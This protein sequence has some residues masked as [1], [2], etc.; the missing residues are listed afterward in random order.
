[1]DPV[2]FL[3]RLNNN[4]CVNTTASHRSTLCTLSASLAE[5]SYEL[6]ARLR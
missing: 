3:L 1:M 6:R 5:W 2:L 4:E